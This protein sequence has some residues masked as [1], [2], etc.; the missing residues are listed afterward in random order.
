MASLPSHPSM[1]RR[2]SPSRHDASSS[3]SDR[4]QRGRDSNDEAQSASSEDGQTL[5]LDRARPCPSP[6]GRA[7]A[8]TGS[9]SPARASDAEPRKCWICFT[10]ETE[11]DSASSTWRSPCACSL[12]AHEK[13]LLDWIADKQAPSSG[14]AAGDSGKIQCPQCKAEIRLMQPKSL[15]IE[16]VRLV[17]GLADALVIPSF[18]FVVGSAVYSIATVEGI[19]AVFEVFGAEDGFRI[20]NGLYRHPETPTSSFAH[21]LGHVRHHWR[22]V[23]GLPLIPTTLM[24]SRSTIADS[25]LPFVPVLFFCGDFPR[26]DMLEP[27][28]PPS[29]ALTVSLLPY[30]RAAYNAYYRA[31][32]ASRERQWLKEIQPPADE[33]EQDGADMDNAAHQVV[34]VELDIFRPWA[35]VD[36]QNAVPNQA[37]DAAAA[38][39]NAAAPAPAPAPNVAQQRRNR[40][41]RNFNISL[42]DTIITPL[43]FPSIAAAFGELLKHAL[44]KSWTTS[45][46]A[47]KPTGF[48]QSRWARSIVGGCLFVGLKDAVLLY[49]RWKMVQRHRNRA[50]L[51]YDKETKRF[52]LPQKR[53][54]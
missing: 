24:L 29:A 43:F 38:Q 53:R 40:R 21:I 2:Q 11:D 26:K 6:S 35:N 7:S 19:H 4:P 16:L 30:V 32:W 41:E 28:W 20:F 13:C 8:R 12:T 23:L 18:L 45:P 14:R 44:P 39:N 10:D 37:N 36:G 33:P 27:S 50:V 54:T 3:N 17:E 47:G 48:F 25:I 49:V 15:A 5:V 9:E 31:V 34:E 52:V 42:A 22:V 1:Q 46:L 51:E